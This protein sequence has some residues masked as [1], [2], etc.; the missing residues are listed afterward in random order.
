MKKILKS[1]LIITV[2]FTC[3]SSLGYA[4]DYAITGTWEG[5]LKTNLRKIE[6]TA[7]IT[8]DNNGKFTGE[9]EASSGG[10]GMLRGK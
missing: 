2:I 6:I 8:Q 7:G 5:S 3:L 10:Y 9:W 4:T 1:V